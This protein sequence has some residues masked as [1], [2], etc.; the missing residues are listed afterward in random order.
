MGRRQRLVVVGNG[1]AGMRAVEELLARAPERYAITVI[2]A[3]PQLNYNRIM[4]SAV[5]A[6]EKTFDE[7]V[8][9]PRSWY[10]QHAI[11]L[12]T[13]TRVDAIDR[14]ASRVVLAGG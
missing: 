2:G 3:E 13:G 14:A 6:G 12:L 11:R 10:D 9:N 5:L 8:I 7:I 4:L 1:M